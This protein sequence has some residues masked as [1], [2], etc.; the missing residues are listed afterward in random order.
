MLQRFPPALRPSAS[1]RFTLT[2]AVPEQTT[3]AT[4][5]PSQTKSRNPQEDSSLQNWK[6]KTQATEPTAEKANAPETD[7]AANMEST[8]KVATRPNKSRSPQT[9]LNAE[10][11]KSP[12]TQRATPES[13]N[14]RHGKSRNLNYWA[15]GNQK[16]KT[17]KPGNEKAG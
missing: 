12:K 6:N 7:N 8:W 13:R 3:V 14:F 10:P 16:R 1:Q 15:T 17:Q 2:S 4:R 11:E 5:K 9:P